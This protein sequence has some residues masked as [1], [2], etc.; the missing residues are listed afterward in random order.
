MEL[1]FNDSLFPITSTIGF[2]EADC[3]AAANCYLQWQIPLKRSWGRRVTNKSVNGDLLSVLLQLTPL[4]K[5]EPSRM[6]FVP[7]ASKWTAYFDNFIT[8]ADTFPVLSQLTG[9]LKCL[10]V[11]AT[12]V[13]HTYRGKGPAAMGRYGAAAIDIFDP[14][15]GRPPL[16][17]LRS[18]AALN[19]GG[20]W[21]FDLSGAQQPFEEPAYYEEK[22]KRDRFPPMLLD[23]YLRALGIRAFDP[24][25]YMPAG[26]EAA[27]VEETYPGDA[28]ENYVDL[29]D[30]Q[31]AQ[32]GL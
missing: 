15:H 13:P 28:P 23:R 1:L 7:T 6:L 14:V 18:I 19:D 22:H 30:L 16:R 20:R 8:G 21:K 24:D 29:K 9:E 17:Y 2:I 25:F 5:T 27:L 10:G 4:R 3:R 26:A 12:A 32:E 11:R 31:R